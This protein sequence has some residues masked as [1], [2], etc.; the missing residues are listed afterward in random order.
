VA[1]DLPLALQTLYAELVERCSMARFTDDFPPSGSFL[2]RT[3]AGRDYWYFQA[4]TSDGR[5][6]RYVGPDSPELRQRI[7]RHREAK[8]DRR[9]RRQ[10][11]VALQRVGLPVSDPT[12]GRVLEALAEAGVFRLR[13][14]VVGTVAY[15]S[16][17]GLLGVRLADAEARTA[18][19]DL[20]QFR[21]VSIAVE[22][23]ID[24]PFGDILARVDP[25]FRAVPY[26]MDGRHS[27]SFVLGDGR[28][29]VDILVPNRGPD[30]DRPV[31][32]PALRTEGQPLRYLD[33]LIRD[34]VRA[35]ALWGAG[36]PIN[37]PAPERYA[38]HKLLVSRMRIATADSQAKAQKDLR[39]AG[40]LARILALR[41]PYELRDLWAEL[42]GRGARWR[43]LADEGAT[44]LEPGAREALMGAVAGVTP[45]PARSDGLGS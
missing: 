7:V 34:E 39:Q 42:R 27:H 43:R 26:A 41:R 16:Y 13:A 36:V 23:A 4:A 19:L 21:E 25:G 14:V 6:Q 28:Y 10:M 32:L 37:V 44:L 12:T 11:V 8:D 33:F 15:Q 2:K 5:R 45:A 31:P 20:A 18:D 3:V 9:E 35:V 17:S 1:R 40:E 24:L 29:R 22:D 38:L 30:A